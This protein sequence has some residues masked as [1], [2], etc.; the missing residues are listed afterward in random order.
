MAAIHIVGSPYYLPKATLQVLQSS[1]TVAEGTLMVLALAV[2]I[3]MQHWV[4]HL[5]PDCLTLVLK[6]ARFAVQSQCLDQSPRA[7]GVELHAGC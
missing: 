2:L 1:A 3:Q 5:V 6:E 7:T 4:R